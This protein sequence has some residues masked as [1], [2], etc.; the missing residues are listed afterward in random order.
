[1]RGVQHGIRDS[2][3]QTG[4]AEAHFVQG[5]PLDVRGTLRQQD[6]SKITFNSLLT[7]ARGWG[8]ARGALREYT[9]GRELHATSADPHS[10]T[11]AS[12]RT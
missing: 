2:R 3:L 8:R 5:R 1:M 11:N 10:A 7:A 12:T 6:H 9:I 4:R